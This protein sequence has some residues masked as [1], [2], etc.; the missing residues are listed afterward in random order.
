MIARAHRRIGL[1]LALGFAATSLPAAPV[2][3][4]ASVRDVLAALG[5]AAFDPIASG[6]AEHAIVEARSS[7]LDPATSVPAIY[8]L[9]VDGERS[10][11]ELA[12]WEKDDRL[13]RVFIAMLFHCAVGEEGER[14][15]NFPG[16]DPRRFAS[17][18]REHRI[19]EIAWVREHRS[20]LAAE[21]TTVFARAAERTPDYQRCLDIA[22]AGLG[23]ALTDSDLDSTFYERAGSDAE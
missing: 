5:E 16:F 10:A 4:F 20:A 3:S 21:L 13:S 6:S 14:M 15:S 8:Q 19:T 18:E 9:W 2:E 11:V 1:V 17:P 22:G 12:W 7:I 23:T